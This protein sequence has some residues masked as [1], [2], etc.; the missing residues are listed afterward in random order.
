MGERLL[1]GETEHDGGE[2]TADRQ[3]LRLDAGD[4]QRRDHDDEDRPEPDQEA[5]GPGR[6]GLEAPEQRRLE[7]LRERPRE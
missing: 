6:A 1:G 5:D 7:A 3:R 2:G 4:P